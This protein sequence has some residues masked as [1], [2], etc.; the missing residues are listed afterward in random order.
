MSAYQISI[1]DDHNAPSTAA[2]DTNLHLLSHLDPTAPANSPLV[3]AATGARTPTA[4]Q[5]KTVE[6]L[7]ELRHSQR[8]EDLLSTARPSSR[9]AEVLVFFI[10]FVLRPVTDMT[11]LHL[12]PLKVM[13][14]KVKAEEALDAAWVHL[15]QGTDWFDLPEY[16]LK[17]RVHPLRAGYTL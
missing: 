14:A 8:K 5:I 2:T 11:I 16:T 17:G 10:I 9:E 4:R 13:M 3:L 15:K 12:K 6:D 7:G 1:D